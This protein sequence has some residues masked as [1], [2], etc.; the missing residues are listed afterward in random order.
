MNMFIAVHALPQSL[1]ALMIE[2]VHSSVHHLC[3]ATF[4]KSCNAEMWM[5]SVCR[6]FS[7]LGRSSLM[8]LSPI[9]PVCFSHRLPRKLDRNCTLPGWAMARYGTEPGR[10]T[11]ARKFFVRLRCW[12]EESIEHPSDNVYLCR[13]I[14]VRVVAKRSCMVMSAHEY[15]SHPVSM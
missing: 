13:R 3:W 2:H 15:R 7:S 9:Q 8:L 12:L 1:I 11:H 14:Y 5:Y 6:P 4:E 10:T